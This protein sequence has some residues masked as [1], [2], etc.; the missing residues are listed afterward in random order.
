[1]N[2]DEAVR[3]AVYRGYVSDG[4]PP[5]IEV[6]AVQL[7]LSADAVRDALHSLQ[8]AR[9]VVLRDDEIIMAHPFASIPLGFSVMGRDTL[10][11]GGCAWDS[12]AI[13]QLCPDDP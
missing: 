6:M 10:W 11:W 3:L 12:F 8:L 4:R 2:H 7:A 1:M 5:S 13:P 9:H